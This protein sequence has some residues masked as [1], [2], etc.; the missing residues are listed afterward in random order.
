[1]PKRI[2]RKVDARNV[3]YSGRS[4]DFGSTPLSIMY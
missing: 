2:E 4:S 3:V 1:M